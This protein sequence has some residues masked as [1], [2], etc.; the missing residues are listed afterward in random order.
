MHAFLEHSMADSK[1]TISINTV[2]FLTQKVLKFKICQMMG[3]SNS[4]SILVHQ[5]SLTFCMKSSPRYSG[6]TKTVCS[7]SSTETIQQSG[8]LNDLRLCP[9]KRDIAITSSS[10]ISYPKRINYFSRSLKTS[11]VRSVAHDV[12]MVTYSRPKINQQTKS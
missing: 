10:V 11:V 8:M 5:N 7:S 6:P 1:F 4:F 12:P 9:L 3:D 2:H